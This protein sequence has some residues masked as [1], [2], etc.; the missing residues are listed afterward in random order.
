MVKMLDLIVDDRPLWEVAEEINA[1]G[2]R[3]RRG[4]EWSQSQIFDLL[5]RL[6]EV[7]PDVFGTDDWAQLRR[8]RKRRAP[9][10]V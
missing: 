4:E 3:N 9:R 1:Q 8:L 10:A 7:A 5:P 2:L 6:I